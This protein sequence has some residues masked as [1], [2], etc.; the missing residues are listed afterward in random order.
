MII[1]IILIVKEM[2]IS[3]ETPQN[4]FIQMIN[5]QKQKEELNDIW[6][7]SPFKDM[8]ILQSNNV[9]NVGET[10]IQA[11]CDLCQ[12][13]SQIDGIKTKEKGGGK[14]DG[15]IQGKTIEIKTSHRG[16]CYS[17]FQHELGEFPWK[18]ELMLFIDVSPM[19]IYLTIFKNF[20]EEFYKSGL[21]CF[22]YF[23]T[24]K[25]TWRKQSGAFKLDTTEKINEE[26]VI[27]GYTYKIN[28]NIDLNDLKAFILSK[29]E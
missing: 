17:N 25:I 3:K 2:E 4:V 29:I 19:F 18:S 15:L 8:V 14:G 21:K 28:D 23:P 22:P 5:I 24:R 11:I 7:N 26:N 10:Y 13:E 1:L 6:K 12:I 20:D 16:S 9:G 27:N